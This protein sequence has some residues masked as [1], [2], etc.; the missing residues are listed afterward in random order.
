MTMKRFLQGLIVAAALGLTATVGEAQNS[1]VFVSGGA[2]A[3]GDARSFDLLYIPFTSKYASGGGGNVGFELPLKRSKIFGLELS[4]GLSQNNLELTNQN[5]NPT[6]TASY[7]LRDNRFSADIV[8]H[9]PS[10]YRNIRPYFVAGPEY[11]RYSPTSAAVSYAQSHGFGA[12]AAV[13]KL[14]SEGHGGVNIG[15]GLDYQLTEKWGARIDVRD[16]L[17]GSPML[18]LPY[19]ITPTSN[20]YF[21]ISGNA[22]NIQYTI[23][24]VYHFGG[25]KPSSAETKTPRTSRQPSPAKEKSSAKEKSPSKEKSSPTSVFD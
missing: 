16:H 12:S 8:V 19:G 17:T 15:G 4:Y 6:T 14:S 25:G 5:T 18:G 2:N 11:D 9:S 21:P 20:A 13:A 7:G 10:T 1:L 3:L 22:H 23:G 24:I